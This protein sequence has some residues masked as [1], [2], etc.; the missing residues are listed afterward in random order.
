M[1]RVGLAGLGTENCTLDSR[2]GDDLFRA[3]LRL[4]MLPAHHEPEP[5]HP[6]S[7]GCPQLA[8]IEAKATSTLNYLIS[9]VTGNL[10]PLMSGSVIRPMK[11]GIIV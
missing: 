6:E 10:L 5:Q 3:G 4:Q 2:R 7:G 9:T 1:K 11:P 8:K